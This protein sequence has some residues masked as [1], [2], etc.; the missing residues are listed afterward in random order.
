[1]KRGNMEVHNYIS[2]IQIIVCIDSCVPFEDIKSS[3]SFSDTNKQMLFFF[4]VLIIH[5]SVFLLFLFSFQ[6]RFSDVFNVALFTGGEKQK[7]TVARDPKRTIII[8]CRLQLQI[9]SSKAPLIKSTMR[10]IKGLIFRRKIPIRYLSISF[11]IFMN[12]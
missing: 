1:M 9:C 7:E 10:K 11:F 12:C 8:I 5:I 3:Y 6:R 4:D 2:L